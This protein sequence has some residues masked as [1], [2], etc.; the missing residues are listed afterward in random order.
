MVCGGISFY[1]HAR[2]W[3]PPAS[4][5]VVLALHQERLAAKAGVVAAGIQQT[6]QNGERRLWG[7]CYEAKWFYSVADEEAGL[8]TQRP[9]ASISCALCGS[10]AV[11]S[12][13]RSARHRGLS[14]Q[15]AL[16][17]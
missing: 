7:G 15:K 14:A 12:P 5:E 11:P 9:R 2:P 1:P 13:A 3:C 10:F 8:A 4:L 6:W 16:W 17:E